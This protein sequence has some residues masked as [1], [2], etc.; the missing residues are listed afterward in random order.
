MLD[1]YDPY[2]LNNKYVEK[3]PIIEDDSV[4]YRNEEIRKSIEALDSV[5]NEFDDG[6]GKE[7][8]VA[9][10]GPL[11]PPTP[12]EAATVIAS[13]FPNNKGPTDP[14]SKYNSENVL[15]KKDKGPVT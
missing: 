5:L 10:K 3:P 1:E 7:D 12:D 14:P 11:P 13:F 9:K 2:S 8:E 15:F 4:D 6:P